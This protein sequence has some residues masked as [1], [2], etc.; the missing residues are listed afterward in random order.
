MPVE[1]R[2]V[3]HER[4]APLCVCPSCVH[5]GL[6]VTCPMA[7]WRLERVLCLAAP[8]CPLLTGPAG[9]RPVP[10][11][12]PWPCLLG[13][14]LFH[15]SQE[16]VTQ[17]RPCVGPGKAEDR[18]Q[19]VCCTPLRP[20]QPQLHT[21][22]RKTSGGFRDS[23]CC[24]LQSDSQTI[25]RSWLCCLPFGWL[26]QVASPFSASQP[27][28]ERQEQEVR[29]SLCPRLGGEGRGPGWLAPSSAFPRG[30]PG[31]PGGRAEPG[32]PGHHGPFSSITPVC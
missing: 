21:S 2:W 6:P 31:G 10:S 19:W 5:T 17:G 18:A 30:R 4:R 27:R 16:V 11:R 3:S 8:R 25:P 23:P 9:P 14:G 32:G 29:V 15:G 28:G 26:W 7:A 20:P 1:Q 24:W 22:H 12:P 13:S